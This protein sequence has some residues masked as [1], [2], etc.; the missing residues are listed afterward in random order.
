MYGSRAEGKLTEDLPAAPDT[1]YAASKRAAEQLIEYHARSGAIGGVILR[2]F[3]ISGAFKGRGDQDQSRIIP[4]AL[5][6]AAGTASAVTINGDGSAEREF[7]H[8]LDVAD[9][10]RRAVEAARPGENS[11]YNVG[12]GAG[13]SMADVVATVAEI[14]GQP[15]AVEHGPPRPEPQTLVADSAAIQRQL[16]WSAPRS[17]LRNIVRDAW[18]AVST[19]PSQP[20]GG[21]TV[22]NGRRES[23]SLR[24]Y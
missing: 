23:L 7:T 11:Y 21:S 14:T 5:S 12:T 20:Q 10:Y 15:I 22:D 13:V 8:V 3:A 19:A 4:K 1:P 18:D 6:V 24:H 16:G 9:A 2:C 17:D